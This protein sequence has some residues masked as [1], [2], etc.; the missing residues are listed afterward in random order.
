MYKRQVLLDSRID[1]VLFFVNSS[2]RCFFFTRSDP[3]D[4]RILSID[5]FFLFVN[6]SHRYTLTVSS[7]TLSRCLL[8]L[9]LRLVNTFDASSS[10]SSYLHKADPFFLSTL[11]HSRS[12][13]LVHRHPSHS[14][15][16]SRNRSPNRSLDRSS[17]S[18]L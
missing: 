8:L 1:A 11:A 13:A 9:L 17:P 6:S 15:W 4:A 5:A 2:D 3:I 7:D 16:H 14:S 12:S 10:F 18:V